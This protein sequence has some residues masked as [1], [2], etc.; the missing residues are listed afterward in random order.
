MKVM[1]RKT[2][3]NPT[4]RTRCRHSLFGKLIVQ[5]EIKERD[6]QG[7]AVLVWRDARI[8]DMSLDPFIPG[9]FQK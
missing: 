4:G 8:E 5:V 6:P 7:D 9:C 1:D 3:I 2:I